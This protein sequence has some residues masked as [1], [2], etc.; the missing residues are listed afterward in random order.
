M[1]SAEEW[2]GRVGESWAAEW[3][4]TDR[5]FTNFT[6]HLDAAIRDAAPTR[7]K[8]LDI[9]CGAGGTSLALAEAW[10]DLGIVGVDLSSDLLAVAKERAQGRSGLRFVPG[11]AL[12]VA[13]EEAP[14]DFFYSRHGVMFFADPVAAFAAFRAA[15]SPAAPLVFSCFRAVIHNSWASEVPGAILG[16]VPPEPQAGAPGPFA[17]ADPERVALILERAG[18]RDVVHRA[19]DFAYRAGAGEDSVADAV[20]FFS[21]I[22]PAAPL[23]RA[24]PED[25]RARM[26]ER[27]AAVAERHCVGDV[28]EFS[29]SAWIWSARAEG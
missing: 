23:L 17:F 6:P 21:R 1:T 5:S 28:V 9:G 24:A 14:I 3:R 22:G 7:G 16:T 19:V 10:P 12:R 13:A 29:A 15:A 8:A 2:S 4:R 26:R 25:E 11:D 18:W 27:L 20:A